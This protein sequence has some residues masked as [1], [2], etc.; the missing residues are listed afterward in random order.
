MSWSRVLRN[1]RRWFNLNGRLMG[2]RDILAATR[3]KR[4]VASN[5]PSCS[6]G[7]PLASRPLELE[8]E[9]RKLHSL[10]QGRAQPELDSGRMPVRQ[11]F[12]QSGK[13]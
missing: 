6:S 1:E 13:D 9:V 10:R 12:V 3:Q 7:A 5:D 4:L 11:A 2:L 8:R